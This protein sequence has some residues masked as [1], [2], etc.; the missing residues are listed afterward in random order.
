METGDTLWWG[1]L[2][3][4]REKTLPLPRGESQPPPPYIK[5]C[6]VLLQGETHCKY[7]CGLLPQYILIINLYQLVVCS[8][9][10]AMAG[11]LANFNL[12]ACR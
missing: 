3:L 9:S 1:G 11:E 5:H 7:F 6:S 4:G 12:Y 2:H 8:F 10:A